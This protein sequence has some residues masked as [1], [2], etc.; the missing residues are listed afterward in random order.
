MI[1]QGVATLIFLLWSL[2]LV[3]AQ[4][5]TTEQRVD[6]RITGVLLAAG[7][8]KHDDIVTVDISVQEKPLVLRLGKVEDLTTREKAQAVKDEVLLR[9]VRFTGAESLMSQLLKSEATGKAMTIEGWL[10]TK[11]RLFQVTAV[12][13]ATD[14]VPA[15]K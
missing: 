9:K 1:Y 4:P 6:L 8:P 12:K 3:H 13:E 2:G 11:T 5:Y 14:I 7:A 10:N 15:F